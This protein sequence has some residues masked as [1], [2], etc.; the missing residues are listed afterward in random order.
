[1]PF[2]R[3][4]H[5]ILGEIR[6]RFALKIDCGPERAMDHLV[7]CLHKD[8]TVSGQRSDQLIFLKTPSWESHYWSPEMTVRIEVEEYTDFTTVSCLVGPRQT[9]W[10]LWAFIYSSILLVTVFGGLFGLVQYQ[11]SGSSPWIWVVPIGIM[12]LSTAFVA[13]KIGQRKG[14]DQMLHLI[15]FLYHSLDEIGHLERIERR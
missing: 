15:S 1:M 9:V 14:R 2:N 11:Q 7:S 8:N 6:P 13:S 5:S 10:V 4:N 3:L 12:L